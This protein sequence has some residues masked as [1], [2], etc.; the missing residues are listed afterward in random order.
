MPARK[1]KLKK[2]ATKS[3]KTVTNRN[4]RKKAPLVASSLMK[5]S[6]MQFILFV[7]VFAAIGSYMIFRSMAATVTLATLEAEV[8]TLPAGASLIS[9]SSASGGKGMLMP[10]NGNSSGTFSLNA[11][12]TQITIR[13]RGTQCSGAPQAVIGIDGANIQTASVSSSSW[14]D[15][16]ATVNLASGSHSISLS[17]TNDYNQYKGKSHSLKCSRDLYIDKVTFYGPDQTPPPVNP[18][19]PV[20]GAVWDTSKGLPVVLAQSQPTVIKYV[21]PSGNDANDGSSSSP[22]RTLQYAFSKTSTPGHGIDQVIVR[23]GTYYGTANG[24]FAYWMSANVVGTSDRPVTFRP[25]NPGRA[26]ISSMLQLEGSSYFRITGFIFDGLDKSHGAAA[27]IG[28]N[29]PVKFVEVSYNEIKNFRNPSASV[30]YN[31]GANGIYIGNHSNSS[32]KNQNVYVIGNKIHDIGYN[33]PYDHGMYL[34]HVDN[35]VIAN[36]VLY[37]IND[38]YGI[39]IYGNFDKSWVI[40][41]TVYNGSTVGA[42]A[43]IIAATGGYPDYNVIANNLFA[44]HY[45][46]NNSLVACGSPLND[47]VNCGSPRSSASGYAFDNCCSAS[48]GVGNSFRNNRE[49]TPYL[50]NVTRSN[51]WNFPSSASVSNNIAATVAFADEAGKDFRITSGTGIINVAENFGLILDA[52]GQPRDSLPDIG[53]YETR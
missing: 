50:A 15:Y 47:G 5:L 3:K 30:V 23:D 2:T 17:F 36:N 24:E 46:D 20:S 6:K 28:N 43:L 40:N 42:S 9:D 4:R 52:T 44:K 51:L 13:A 29:S 38:G 39:H 21:S 14:T 1:N 37:N 18:P 10:V 12:A 49:W 32:T 27:F 22:W 35:A 7:L 48:S 31:R 19:T 53:A 26:V 41:N 16:S 11:S 34:K 33:Y 8:L 45:I 25:E